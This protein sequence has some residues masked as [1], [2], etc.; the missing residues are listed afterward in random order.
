MNCL[1]LED[2]GNN[3]IDCS[4]MNDGGL[5]TF[6]TAADIKT[7]QKIGEVSAESN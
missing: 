1:S 7:I 3:S 6:K 5:T 4:E 2:K